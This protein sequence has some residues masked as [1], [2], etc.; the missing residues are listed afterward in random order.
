M[1]YVRTTTT[2]TH[3][4]RG[5][6]VQKTGVV[7]HLQFIEGCRHPF[8]GAEA[9]PHGPDYSADHGDSAV[10][11]RFAAVDVPAVLVVQILRCR[12]G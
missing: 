5:S 1:L 3:Q 10:A 8:R 2:T 7:P 12:R 11:V 9:V 4:V 6:T